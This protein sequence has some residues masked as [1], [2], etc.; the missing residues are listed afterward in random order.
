VALPWVA[1]LPWDTN[2]VTVLVFLPALWSGRE[3]IARSLG[4][5]RRAGAAFGGAAALFALATLVAVVLSRHA[6]V[7]LVMAAAWCLIALV[8]VLA[9]QLVREA[10]EATTTA[11]LGALALSGAVASAMHAWRWKLGAEPHTAF[12]VFTRL[13]GLHALSSAFAGAV[14]VWRTRA[15]PLPRRLGWLLVAIVAWAGLLWTGSRSPLLGLAVAFAVCALAVRGR[16][17]WRLGATLGVLGVAGAAVSWCFWTPAVAIGWWQIAERSAPSLG[18]KALTSHRTDFW[19]R[20]FE[21]VRAAPWFGHGPD[22]YGFLT[23]ALEGAQPHNVVLQLLLDVGAVG[24]LAA[25][26]LLAIV[27]GRA[28]RGARTAAAWAPKIWLALALGTAVAGLFDG[29]FFYPLALLPAAVALGAAAASLG[30]VAEN[31]AASPPAPRKAWLVPAAGATAVL[32]LHGWLFQN[33]VHRAPPAT[34]EALVARVWRVFP[35]VT[36][37]IDFWIDAWAERF[38]EAALA[39]SRLATQHSQG[40]DFFRVKTALLLARRGEHRAAAAELERAREEALPEQQPAIERLLGQAR[41]AAARTAAAPP[42]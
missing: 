38:P 19:A 27:L 36:Y 8:A 28:V 16:E 15:A 5:L 13:M 21:H 4:E 1:R 34:P 33:V 29:Y 12:Y 11:L 18:A 40:P 2:R 10:P 30:A 9:R 25:G 41:A 31:A 35:S 39:A 20:A 32:A 23:P 22:A 24:T 17:R 14:L 26:A 6:P 3:A 42:P 7:S 37:N